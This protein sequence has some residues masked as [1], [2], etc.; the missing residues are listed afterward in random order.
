MDGTHP[1]LVHAYCVV[2]AAVL[3][4]VP[5]TLVVALGGFV[6][7]LVDAFELRVVRT[8]TFDA[9]LGAEVRVGPVLA[10]DV[11]AQLH[12]TLF[13]DGSC[14]SEGARETNCFRDV[15]VRGIWD[16]SR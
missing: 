1:D 9:V 2:A 12:A 6:D 8:E 13:R 4:V 10:A 11:E 5:G 15:V 7:V 16:A 3:G 14:A